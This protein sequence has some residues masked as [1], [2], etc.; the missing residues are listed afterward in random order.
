[1]YDKN[2]KEQTVESDN[3]MEA[4]KKVPNTKKSQ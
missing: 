4:N 1:M 2:I 3:D